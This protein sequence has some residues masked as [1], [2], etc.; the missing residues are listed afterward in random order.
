MSKTFMHK[1]CIFND[2]WLDTNDYLINY[3][4]SIGKVKGCR[5]SLLSSHFYLL[6]EFIPLVIF[7]SDS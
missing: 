6:N 3:T 1:A 5:T 2:Y 7:E 4:G